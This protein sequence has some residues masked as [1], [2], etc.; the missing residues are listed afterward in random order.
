MLM[1]FVKAPARKESRAHVLSKANGSLLRQ[2]GPHWLGCHCVKWLCLVTDGGTNTVAETS[3]ICGADTKSAFRDKN[4][5]ST[6]L[7][8][9]LKYIE[10]L[11]RWPI[12]KSTW[13]ASLRS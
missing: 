9:K 13:H 2:A 8:G 5:H 7:G 11:G 12:E 1:V 6:W 4:I 3:A 10:W